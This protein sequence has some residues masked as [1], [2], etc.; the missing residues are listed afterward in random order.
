LTAEEK[1]EAVKNFDHLK[2]LKFSPYP[3]KAF[4]KIAFTFWKRVGSMDKFGSFSF[5]STKTTT[6]G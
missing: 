3:S 5:R 2:K 6:T 4:T 1:Q